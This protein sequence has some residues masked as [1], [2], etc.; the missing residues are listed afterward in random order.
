[1]ETIQKAI[2][3]VHKIIMVTFVN[4]LVELYQELGRTVVEFK[5]TVKMSMKNT[6]LKFLSSHVS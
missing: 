2:I 1:M 3:H 6:G 5:T 4:I